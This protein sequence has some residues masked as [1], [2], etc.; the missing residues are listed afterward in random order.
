MIVLPKYE[1]IVVKYKKETKRDDL[2]D[3]F[4]Q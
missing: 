2:N 3:Q 1:L 4:H